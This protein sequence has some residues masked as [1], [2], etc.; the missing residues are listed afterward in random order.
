M[1]PLVNKKQAIIE[2]IR[3]GECRAAIAGGVNLVLHPMHFAR[4]SSKGMLASD[5][6]CKP[7]GAGADGFVDGEGVGLLVVQEGVHCA[8]EGGARHCSV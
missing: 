8:C 4:L 1:M 5:G 2:S 6:R 3:R 7:F